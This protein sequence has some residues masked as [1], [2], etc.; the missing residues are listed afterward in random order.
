MKDRME[1]TTQRI[2]ELLEAHAKRADAGATHTV[3]GISVTVDSH[4]QL[5]HVQLDEPSIDPS[6]RAAIE[7]AI[8]EA[9]NTAMWQ[10]V[11]SSSQTLSALHSSEE[12]KAA[13][14]EIFGSRVA[15]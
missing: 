3:G 12:W 4:L 7:N 15:R 10:V 14:G 1:A 13:M 6:R 2:R 8:V 5:T 9:V 11:K